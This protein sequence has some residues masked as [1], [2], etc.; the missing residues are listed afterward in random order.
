MTA[1]DPTDYL[2]YLATEV[3][4]IIEHVQEQLRV[5]NPSRPATSG[6]I[7]T[8]LT[9]LDAARHTLTESAAVFCDNTDDLDTYHDGRPVQTRLDLERGNHYSHV[10]HPYPDHPANQPHEL[11][12]A[13]TS[14]GVRK[15]IVVSGPG[16]LDAVTDLAAVDP[17]KATWMEM[18]ISEDE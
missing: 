4:A 7:K 13:T 8:I 18:D 16:R 15:R 10:W 1:P 14:S 12:T 2:K 6:D 3:G 11:G 9:Q 17:I 5:L